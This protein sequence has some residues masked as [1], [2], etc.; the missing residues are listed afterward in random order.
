M[1]RIFDIIRCTSSV[2]KPF[3][4][5]SCSLEIV[6][7]F[8]MPIFVVRRNLMNVE[9]LY[10]NSSHQFNLTKSTGHQQIKHLFSLI[11]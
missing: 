8:N 7:H 9:L 3:L 10:K 2:S 4:I 11:V 1:I 6:Y 5:L